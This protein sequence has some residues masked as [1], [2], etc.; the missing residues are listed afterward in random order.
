MIVPRYYQYGCR[1]D[2]FQALTRL[3]RLTKIRP[4]EGKIKLK[5]PHKKLKFHL[6][7][8]APVA[9]TLP[10]WIDGIAGYKPD[11]SD[12]ASIID[13]ISHRVG[14]VTPRVNMK[15]AGQ[16]KLFVKSMLDNLFPRLPADTDVSLDAWLETTDYP[17]TRKD[18]LRKADNDKAE[19]IKIENPLDVKSFIKEE[20]YWDPKVHRTIN[21]RVDQFKCKIGPWV[22]AVEKLIFKMPWF[23]KTIP[24][25]DRAQVVLQKLNKVNR[26]K[27]STDFT[28]FESSFRKVIMEACEFQLFEHVTKDIPGASEFMDEYRKISLTNKLKF[29][30]IVALIAAKRMS[31]EMS[32]SIAN[33]FTNLMLILFTAYKQGIRFADIDLFVE[34]DDSIISC[35]KQLTTKYFEK[36]GFVVK[37]EIHTDIRRASFCGLIFSEPGHIIRDPR[38]V[39]AKFGWAMRQYTNSSDKV[40]MMLLRAKALSLACEYPNCPV[41][42]PFAHRVME[43]TKSYNIDRIVMKANG[44]SFTSFEKAKLVHAMVVKPWQVKPDIQPMSR[45]LMEQLYRVPV[46]LQF[47]WED[48]LS[49]VGFGPIDLPGVYEFFPKDWAHNYND[50]V[51]PYNEQFSA[52]KRNLRRGDAYSTFLPDNHPHDFRAEKE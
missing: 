27:M 47:A 32:T 49:T 30:G 43:L 48:T 8:R 6:E 40:R 25:Q 21:S 14:G 18:Q 15:T 52:I 16:F 23:I 1:T 20:T 37:M 3:T 39:L 31:G 41:I 33:G 19:R 22:H 4:F 36:L 28:A 10:C 13:G 7:Y 26:V 17:E 11:D 9:S 42:A 29:D 38:P 51:R 5:N 50:F 35:V 12:L 45:V 46:D 24:V 34:G 2:E 44:Q